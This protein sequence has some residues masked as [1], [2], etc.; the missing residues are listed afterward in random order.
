MQRPVVVAAT[1][2]P[3]SDGDEATRLTSPAGVGRPGN[4]V[5]VLGDLGVLVDKTST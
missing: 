4:A 1:V 2:T 5:A 3:D